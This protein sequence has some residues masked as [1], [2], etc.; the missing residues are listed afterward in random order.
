MSS[1]H[2]LQS[3]PLPKVLAFDV[4][5]TVVDWH[6]SIA[7]EV[8]DRL[9]KYEHDRELSVVLSPVVVAGLSDYVPGVGVGGAF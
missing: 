6:S 9:P 1:M 4:F 7:R 8:Y 5:G 3:T 2:N